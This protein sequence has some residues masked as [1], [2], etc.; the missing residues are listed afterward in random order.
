MA[1]KTYQTEAELLAEPKEVL[2]EV[3]KQ[4][5]CTLEL[6]EIKPYLTDWNVQRQMK[7]CQCC[8]P[9]C[10]LQVNV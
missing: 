6:P 4:L 1:L 8:R 2:V 5:H 10:C 9:F 3:I 7:Q